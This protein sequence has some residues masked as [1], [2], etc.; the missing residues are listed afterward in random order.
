M[1]NSSISNFLDFFLNFFDA[2]FIENIQ[3]KQIS[4]DT[5][6]SLLI[7]QRSLSVKI[8]FYKTN[9]HSNLYKNDE[10]MIIINVQHESC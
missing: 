2:C 4:S 5:F 8:N 10:P 6:G 1:N 7:T 9:L 3:M